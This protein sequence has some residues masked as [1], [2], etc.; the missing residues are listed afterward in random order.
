MSG[1]RV[2]FFL[3]YDPAGG[4]TQAADNAAATVLRAEDRRTATDYDRLPSVSDFALAFTYAR[5]IRNASARQQSGLIHRLD[6]AFR[7]SGVVM[8]P[9]GGGGLIRKDLL[10]P[11]QLIEGVETECVPIVTRDDVATVVSRPILSMFRP[12]DP[13]ISAVWPDVGSSDVLLDYAHSEFKSAVDNAWVAWPRPYDEWRRDEVHGWPEEQQWALRILD[14]AR[15]ELIAVKVVTREDGTVA[16]TK[17]NARQFV[18]TGR[19]D[20]AYTHVYA[21][22]A[23]L[24][25]LKLEGAEEQE[26]AGTGAA[27][28]GLW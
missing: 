12:K 17:N 28:G 2:H 4:Q 9:G 25:W 10:E 19:K 24:V 26:S 18:A 3:G 23:F 14:M 13:G 15:K 22:V 1:S 16:Y 27:Y 21:W 5:V 11:R 20:V 7:F 8:D 6:R